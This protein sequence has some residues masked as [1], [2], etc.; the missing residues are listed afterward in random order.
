MQLGLQR[1][2]KTGSRPAMGSQQTV[3]FNA[4]YSENGLIVYSAYERNDI[5]E[6]RR[7]VCNFAH[8][9]ITGVR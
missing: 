9:A 3:H 1:S 4:A 5:G 8:F 7:K 6:D 2:L